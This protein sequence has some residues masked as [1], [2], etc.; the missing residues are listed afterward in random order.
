MTLIIQQLEER[1]SRANTDTDRIDISN[2]LA[3]ELRNIDEERSNALTDENFR[4]SNEL[5]YKKGIAYGFRNKGLTAYYAV[6]YDVALEYLYKASELF[7]ALDDKAGHA[8][9]LLWLGIVFNNMGQ[10]AASLDYYN[11]SLHISER[12]GDTRA[13]ARVLTNIGSVYALIKDNIQALKYFSESLEYCKDLDDPAQKANALNGLG[14]VQ[15][16]LGNHFKALEYELKALDLRQ[17][18]GDVRGIAS[19]L[20]FVGRIHEKM[21]NPQEALRLYLSLYMDTSFQ[22]FQSWKWGRAQIAL[23]TG[24]LYNKLENHDLSR[25]FI[26]NALEIAV[27]IKAQKIESESHLI[28][29]AI[30]KKQDDFK[31]AF[32]HLERYTALQAAIVGEE[33]AKSAQTLETARAIRESEILRNKNQELAKLNEELLHANQVTEALNRHLTEVNRDLELL[34]QEKNEFL[35]IAAH[36]LKNPLTSIILLA[37]FLKQHGGKI[38]DDEILKRINSIQTT[39]E[40]MNTIVTNLLGANA[41]ET[42]RLSL[43]FEKIDIPNIVEAVIDEYRPRADCKG[44]RLQAE[45]PGI[46]ARVL[47]DKNAVYEVLENLLSNAVKYSPPDTTV[48]VKISDN[49]R[50]TTGVKGTVRIEVRDQGPGINQHDKKNLF[51][52]FAR[53][54]AKPTGGESSTGLGLS[55][56]KKMVESMNGTISCES[57]PGNGCTFIIELPASEA[58]SVAA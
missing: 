34:N 30:C 52:K 36:D 18:L 11:Q 39:A 10:S 27:A 4:R 1:L 2:E 5:E 22:G 17:Q 24:K 57:E 42:G 58:I 28:L 6:E 38:S 23:A 45:N 19:S 40:R 29:S 43:K 37:D 48:C 14:R 56:A 32:E 53:L 50:S 7:T 55:I 41:I 8:S 15:S 26:S 46:T 33:V 13:I 21:G 51:K 54:S 12:L 44:I 9:A 49:M 16:S 31:T 3:Y 47:A 35:G 25:D 20:F